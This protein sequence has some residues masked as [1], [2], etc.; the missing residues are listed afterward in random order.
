MTHMTPLDR[1][2]CAQERRIFGMPAVMGGAV[3]RAEEAVLVS[4]EDEGGGKKG[5]GRGGAE[6]TAPRSVVIGSAHAPCA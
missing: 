5:G 6:R 3:G 4:E 2:F 1:S